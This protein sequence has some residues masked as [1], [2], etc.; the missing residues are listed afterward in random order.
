[1]S[2]TVLMCSRNWTELLRSEVQEEDI[3]RTCVLWT[4]RGFEKATW[5]NVLAGEVQGVM[6]LQ[7]KSRII[8]SSDI[9]MYQL[10][11]NCGLLTRDYPGVLPELDTGLESGIY[12]FNLKVNLVSQN[13]YFCF[14]KS[15]VYKTKFYALVRRFGNKI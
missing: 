12:N 13:V 7:C 1:M 8:D 4:K 14:S 6:D 5:I 15:N 3:Y 11:Q 9:L 2:D 10:F